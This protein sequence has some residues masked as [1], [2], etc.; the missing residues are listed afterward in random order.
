MTGTVEDMTSAG[1]AYAVPVSDEQLYEMTAHWLGTGIVAG[2]RVL[3]FEDDTADAVLE[4]LADDRIRVDTALAEGQLTIISAEQTHAVARAPAAQVEALLIARID[5]AAREGWPGIRLSGESS[6]GLL[7]AGGAGLIGYEQSLERVLLARPEARVLCMY[8]RSRFPDEAIKQLTDLH[9]H[10]VVQPALYDDTLLR[11][12]SIGPTAARLAGEV[13]HSN[14]PRI[15]DLID[16][17]LDRALRSHSA[18]TDVTLDLSSLRFLDV[19]GAVGLVH[20]AEEFPSTHRLVLTGIRP[21]VLRVLDRCGAPFAAQLV[22]RPR[23]DE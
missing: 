20:S 21:R 12:T 17:T 16:A 19:A 10:E 14:R 23:V 3:Y 7:E 2:E 8:S 9:R 13:D 5:E 15:R 4:R 22:L 1:H 6:S 11:I 18:P